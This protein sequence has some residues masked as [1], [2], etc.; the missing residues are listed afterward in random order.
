MAEIAESGGG[1]GHKGGKKRA[2]KGS[3]RVDMTPMVDLA[4]L[5]LTFFVLTSTFSK[6]KAM[7]VVYPAKP[8]PKD[9]PKPE[10]QIFNAMT[11]LLS[12]EKIYYYKGA[13]K[14]G[15]TQLTETTFG[16]DGVRKLL[17]EENNYVLKE[18]A[19][20]AAE[21]SKGNMPDSIFN[22]EII[23]AKQDN[24]ALK[25]VIKTDTKATCKNF[26]D[27]IDELKINQIGTV[28]PVDITA[29]EQELL[30]A[31]IN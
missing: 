20:L 11:F 27:L 9:P 3:T 16:A 1:G 17:A 13:F 19:R 7:S 22:K 6:P 30:D 15:E 10:Q 12:E 31:K 28:A 4:F 18:R 29:S 23:K 25:V 8:D 14:K 24:R 5:L 21:F 2:K 26:I